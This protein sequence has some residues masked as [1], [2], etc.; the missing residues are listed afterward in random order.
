MIS[1]AAYIAA[2]QQDG[3]VLESV[4]KELCTEAV[5]MAAVQQDGRVL[6][7]VPEGL[8]TKALCMA[9]VQQDGRALEWV[10]KELCTE[11]VC[12]AAVQQNNKA[13]QWVPQELKDVLQAGKRPSEPG[14]GCEPVPKRACAG[15][16]HADQHMLNLTLEV[17]LLRSQAAAHTQGAAAATYA[18]AN[19]ERVRAQQALENLKYTC[20]MI[21]QLNSTRTADRFCMP[22]QYDQMVQHVIHGSK[23]FGLDE[24]PRWR[25]TSLLTVKF[26]GQD[27]IDDGGLGDHLLCEV[28]ERLSGG[29]DGAFSLPDD[30]FALPKA[31]LENDE[32]DRTLRATGRMLCNFMFRKLT[33][34][35]HLVFSSKFSSFLFAFLCGDE[36]KVFSES[37]SVECALTALQSFD[38]ELAS[39]WKGY[40]SLTEMKLTAMELTND[41]FDGTVCENDIVAVTNLNIATVIKSGCRYKLVTERQRNLKLIR[42]SF[43][44][45]DKPVTEDVPGPLSQILRAA[46]NNLGGDAFEA[47]LCARNATPTLVLGALQKKDGWSEENGFA[48]VALREIIGEL[49]SE[50]IKTFLRFVVGTSTIKEGEQ[51]HVTAAQGERLPESSTCYNELRWPVGATRERLLRAMGDASLSGFQAE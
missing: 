6:R 18:L 51:I 31:C 10:P 28:L 48:F 43:F 14:G 37:A 38:C 46:V 23:G 33:S 12:M 39:S 30:G 20:H 24:L 16:R 2:V 13:L 1:E 17:E 8:R 27:G 7:W 22:L 26:I 9:A 3:W 50:E 40:L 47:L 25:S 19:E 45:V 44:E 35:E 11:A 15:L 49:G 29:C 41:L 4:P 42:D 5:C 34:S 32:N 36:S 21:Q